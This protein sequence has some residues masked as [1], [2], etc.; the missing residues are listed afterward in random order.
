MSLLTGVA[1]RDVMISDVTW[2][3]KL[4]GP[5]TCCRCPQV[6]LYAAGIEG[7]LGEEVES[8]VEVTAGLSLDLLGV[9]LRPVS[10]FTGQSGLMSAVWNAPSELTPALQV[11]RDQL[12]YEYGVPRLHDS[13]VQLIVRTRVG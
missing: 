5:T 7:L 13:H 1:V 3:I 12:N 10:F 4:N 8:E 2:R 11:S 9:S 6:N